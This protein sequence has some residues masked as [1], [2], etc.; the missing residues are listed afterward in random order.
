MLGQ[1]T[2]DMVLF[3]I[4]NYSRE[5]NNVLF[6]LCKSEIYCNLSRRSL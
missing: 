3:K 6:H 1:M 4:T 2:H 5:E